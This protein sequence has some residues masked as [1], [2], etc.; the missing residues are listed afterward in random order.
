M[1]A[2]PTVLLWL[3]QPDAYLRAAEAAGLGSAVDLQT[4]KL[5]ADPP[6]DLLARTE[7]LLAWRPPARL[8]A[9]APRLRWIQS[10][11]AGVEQWLAAGVPEGIVLTCARGTHRL[12]MPENILGALFLLSKQLGPIVLDQRERRW[13]RRVNDTLAG[14]TLGILGLGAIGAEL[15]RKASGLEM[16]VIGTK[17]DAA[18][19]PH[20]ERVFPPAQID[21]VLAESD[22]VVLLLPSTAE[23]RGIISARTLARMKP[24]AYVLNFGRGDLVVDADLVAA[25]SERRIAGA[26]LDVY[27]TEPLPAEHPFWTTDGI[28]VL[29]HVGGLHPQRDMLV[30]R[31]WVENL[32]ALL[33]GRPLREVVDRA[34]GY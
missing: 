25:V 1:S 13:R 5:A 31:L 3:D 27:T 33:A 34:R 23:T 26:V 7:A 32:A 16:R 10:L 2:R 12:S 9:R 11:T 4:V 6:D 29:P 19:V 24:A 18:P 28:V 30:A 22:Y 21:A 17:R 14:K 15:A 20:V 8:A